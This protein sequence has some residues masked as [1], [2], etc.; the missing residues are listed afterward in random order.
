MVCTDLAMHEIRVVDDE[1][2]KETFQRILPLMVDEVHGHMKEMLEV[3][4]ICPNQSFWCSA[5]VLECKKDGGLQFCIDF[6]KL[7]ERTKKD[8]YLPWIQEAIE[9]LVSAGY[10]SYLDLKA[11]FFGR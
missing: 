1:P 9:S 4:A 5:I 11:W 7:N 10:L 2:F 8:S 3:G 6:H